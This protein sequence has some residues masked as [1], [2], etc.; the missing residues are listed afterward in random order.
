MAKSCMKK[1]GSKL[2]L[3]VSAGTGIGIKTKL[4]EGNEEQRK[5]TT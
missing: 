2:I 3:N 4:T 5:F 1:R